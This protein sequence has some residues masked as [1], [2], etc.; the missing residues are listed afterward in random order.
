MKDSANFL[1]YSRE[2]DGE[3]TQFFTKLAVGGGNPNHY[4]RTF[5]ESFFVKTGTLG[6]ELSSETLHLKPGESATVPINAIHHFFNYSDEE[7]TFITEARPGHEG[8]ERVL[9]SSMGWRTMGFVTMIVCRP[10]LCICALWR[11]L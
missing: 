6:I 7:C 10:I 5:V 1:K 9:L 11:L 8:F 3:Y 2:T 4:H